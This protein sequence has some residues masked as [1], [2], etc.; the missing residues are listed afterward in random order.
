M[1]SAPSLFLLSSS[2]PALCI[3]SYSLHLF[4]LSASVPASVLCTCSCSC[5]LFAAPVLSPTPAPGLCSL[6][7][8]YYLLC[9]R[10]LS[11]LNICFR[12]KL[13]LSAPVF[14]ICS[15]SLLH[16]CIVFSAP[17]LRL[18]FSA[19]YSSYLLMICAGSAFLCFSVSV[20][21]LSAPGM[22][23]CLCF[24]ASVLCLSAPG[25]CSCLCY[26]QYFILL[27]SCYV[28][29]LYASLLLFSAYLLLLCTPV[30]ATLL[31]F[32]LCT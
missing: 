17:S 7:L 15:I 28:L 3:C 19:M 1:S 9:S 10:G 22:C 23:S 26:I 5:S 8:F 31:L 25:M 6:G 11:D 24:S 12:S 30:Y 2:V 16:I 4:L 27:F 18:L 21:C 13:V 32:K 29:L 14:S 20:L